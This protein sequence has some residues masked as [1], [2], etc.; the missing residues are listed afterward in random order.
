MP[1]T[2]TTEIYC[3]NDGVYR[4]YLP[5]VSMK[6]GLLCYKCTHCNKP[7]TASSLKIHR[8]IFRNKIGVK[9]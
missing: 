6:S 2:K 7:M 5:W 4:T 1:E 3:E 9:F 8:C